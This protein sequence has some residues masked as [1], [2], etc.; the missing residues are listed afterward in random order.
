MQTHGRESTAF[1][2][3]VMILRFIGVSFV[4]LLMSGCAPSLNSDNPYTREA[5]VEKLTDQAVLAKVAVEDESFFVSES[6]VNKLTDQALLAKMAVYL[7]LEKRYL[8][9]RY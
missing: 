3:H 4:A 6:A 1:H 5:A 7:I 8:S 9:E 2:G